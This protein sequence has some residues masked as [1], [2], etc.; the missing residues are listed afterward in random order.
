MCNNH[1]LTDLLIKERE[2]IMKK[3]NL[4]K[5]VLVVVLGLC[6]TIAINAQV[7]S[8]EGSAGAN[9]IASSTASNNLSGDVQGVIAALQGLSKAGNSNLNGIISSLQNLSASVNSQ[10]GVANF[11]NLS[12]NRSASV[13]EKITVQNLSSQEAAAHLDG[14]I[15]SLEGLNDKSLSNSI[16]NLQSI[17]SG[18]S[19]YNNLRES[20]EE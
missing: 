2:N 8:T 15:S 10:S 6:C 5:G 9:L 11:Q 12:T 19:S 13:E 17:S 3:L 7:S 4:I 20:I 18:F 1:Q 14:I 16:S